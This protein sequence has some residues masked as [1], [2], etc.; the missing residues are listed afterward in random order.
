MI[1]LQK[2]ITDNNVSVSKLAKEMGIES[3]TIYRW[4]VVNKVPKRYYDYFLHKFGLEEKYINEVVNDIVTYQ[5]RNKGFNRYKIC[6][7][8]TILYVDTKIKE[9]E[10]EILIDTE[11]LERIKA[12][13]YRWAVTRNKKGKNSEILHYAIT[14]KYWF[15]ENNV[16]QHTTITLH[17]IILNVDSN[18]FIHVN[19]KDHNTLNNRKYNIEIVPCSINSQLRDKP[20]TNGQTGV[21]NVHLITKYGGKQVYW[22]QIMKNYQRHCWEFEFNQF[23]EA[24]EFARQ[25]RIELFGK[26]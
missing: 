20:N 19:H 13:G 18:R 17:T 22:V 10:F 11:D 15:D 2:Y 8:Y 4:F 16:K 24:C 14:N 3:G 1:G 12:L 5:P 9:S 26:E 21:R 25:K 7:D 6:G 23:E